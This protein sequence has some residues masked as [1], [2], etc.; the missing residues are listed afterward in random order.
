MKVP[1]SVLVITYNEELHIGACL[2]SVAGWAD[3]IFVVDAH[4]TDATRRIAEAEGARVVEHD[5]EYPAQ[6]KNWAL[7]NLPFRNEW[8]LLLDAD[9]HV[10][11]ELRDETAAL[12]VSD[13]NGCDGFWMRYRLIFYGKWIRHCGWYPSWILRLARRSKMRFEDRPVDEHLIV[14]GPTGRLSHDLLHESRRDLAFWIA[15]HNRYSSQNARLY[16]DLRRGRAA[17]DTMQ[18]RLAGGQAERKRYIKERIWPHLPGRGILFFLYM[19]IF[20]LGFLDGY[21]GLMFCAMHGMFQQFITYKVWEL[22]RETESQPRAR[23]AAQQP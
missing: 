14:D 15:K 7:Q 17:G 9:E 21:R 18:P 23:G 6:Q 8:V 13:G 20:R 5:F 22:E 2:R 3:E 1:V 19:Y 16:F 4:S 12:I 11:P 10:P